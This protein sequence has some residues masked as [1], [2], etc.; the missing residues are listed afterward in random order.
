MSNAA[1][2]VAEAKKLGFKRVMIP[3]SNVD[4]VDVRAIEIVG[5][6]TIEEAISEAL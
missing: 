4:S 1:V 3:K 5:V 2:R 6:S